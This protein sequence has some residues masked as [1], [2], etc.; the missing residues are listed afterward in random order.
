MPAAILSAGA[1][2]LLPTACGGSVDCEALCTRT[3][4]CEVAF[5]PS[6][7][8]DE[9]KVEAGER[10]ELDSCTLGCE[11]SPT[12]TV[13]SAGC[14][15]EV[16]IGTDPSTCQDPVLTCLGLEEAVKANDGVGE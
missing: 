1:A 8:P 14:V 13:E 9:L 2:F 12:V 11:E 5:A 7:D 6:D 3:L 10:S 16:E 4:A 15:D